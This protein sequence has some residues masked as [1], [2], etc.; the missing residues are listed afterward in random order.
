MIPLVVMSWIHVVLVLVH[1]NIYEI[2]LKLKYRF[3]INCK[4]LA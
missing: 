2:C 4:F 3:R 1:L